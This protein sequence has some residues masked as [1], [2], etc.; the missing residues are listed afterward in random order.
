MQRSI[1]TMLLASSLLAAPA[2]WA[3]GTIYNV[4][5]VTIT[6]SKSVP[7][8]QLYAVVQEH[9]GSK[10]TT[11]DIIADRDAITK[12]LE[13]A[14]VVGAVNV[15][16]KSTGTQSE[17]IFAIDDQGVQAPTTTTVAPK[18]DAEIFEGNASIPSATLA[19]ASGLTPG[20]DLDNQK[21]LDAQKAIVAAYTA[22]KLPVSLNITGENKQLPNGTYDVIWHIVETKGAKKPKDTKDPGAVTE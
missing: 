22:S 9:P 13:A 1:A 8:A 15:S 10:S 14:H 21:I 19:T 12:V 2:A 3:A 16:V 7:A 5:K 6:G 17:V 20:E 11:D 4:S 18:L